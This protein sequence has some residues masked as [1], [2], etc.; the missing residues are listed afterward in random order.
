[1]PIA[2]NSILEA[3]PNF[4][5]KGLTHR[6]FTP[7]E[8]Q[9]ALSKL[10]SAFKKQVIGYSVENRPIQAIVWGQGQSKVFAWS[11]MHGDEATGTLALLDLLEF[12]STPSLAVNDLFQKIELHLI[13]QVNPDGAHY[14]TRRNAQQIDINRD[15]IKELSPEARIL[16]NYFLNLAPHFGFNLHDQ[17]TLW[18]IKESRLPATLSFLAPAY[19]E[20]LQYEKGRLKAAQVI[21]EI[22]SHLAP[23]IPGQIGLFDDE[24]EP[25]AFGDNFQNLNCST[26]LI[27]AG[28][29]PN[30]IEKQEIRKLYFCA[31][32][33]GLQGIAQQTYTKFNLETYKYIPFNAK[34]L[35]HLLLQEVQLPLVKAS[36][37]LN[38]KEVLL[39][40]SR[41]IEYIYYVED[42]GDLSVWAAYSE[43]K[44]LNL[45]I[46]GDLKIGYKANF[47]LYDGTQKLLSFKDGRISP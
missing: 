14:F 37:G 18:G 31:L 23:L 41:E 5:Y 12:L 22:Y 28:G 38:Y 27:E 25:R 17:D 13:L 47:E 44:G 11:Q 45:E 46:K 39:P 42:L 3:Y 4:K 29:F 34:P 1:M 32:Y 21:A 33:I 26:I 35:F 6:R 19:D 40:E 16:K 2:L 43:V 20:T 36:I 7:A 9:E 24:F 8:V 15:F 30:D 10:S